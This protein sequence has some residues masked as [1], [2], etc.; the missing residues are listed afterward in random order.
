MPS[1]VHSPR[2]STH[3][4]PPQIL[5]TPKSPLVLRLQVKFDQ[6]GS[7]RRRRMRIYL[8]GSPCE[9]TSHWLNVPQGHCSSLS[10]LLSFYMSIVSPSLIFSKGNMFT[11]IPYSCTNLC[12]SL[13]PTST[14]VIVSFF[15]GT[16]STYLNFSVPSTS[17]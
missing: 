2:L 4:R 14:L 8:P 7:R 1:H 5:R 13:C 15:N 16:F 3:K 11:T 9:F 17:S 10:D 12:G 6:W